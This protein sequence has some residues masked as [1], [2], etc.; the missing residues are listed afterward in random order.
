MLCVA[1]GALGRHPDLRHKTFGSS[2]PP[3]WRQAHR[4]VRERNGQ[5]RALR[6]LSEGQR[7]VGCGVTV[8]DRK[9]TQVTAAVM[10]Q[11]G[12]GGRRARGDVARRER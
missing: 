9:A 2:L 4:G 12:R 3:S 1:C 6:G 7:P 10:Q 8:T 11:Q 5:R